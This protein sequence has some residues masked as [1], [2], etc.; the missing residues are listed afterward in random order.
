MF[1]YSR[2]RGVVPVLGNEPVVFEK[3]PPSVWETGVC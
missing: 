3:M 1:G 2:S